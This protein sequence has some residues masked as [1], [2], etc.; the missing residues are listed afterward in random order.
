MPKEIKITPG[1]PDSAFSAV[2]GATGLHT[3]DNNN[4]TLNQPL[5]R[6]MF[7]SVLPE[8]N[9]ETEECSLDRSTYSW[10]SKVKGVSGIKNS[11]KHSKLGGSVNV[12]GGHGKPSS[13]KS[14]GG[15][16]IGGGSSSRSILSEES[17]APSRKLFSS[18]PSK[19]KR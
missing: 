4:I 1:T 18:S 2:S 5:S 6:S 16:L 7:K 11:S 8:M 14:R 10:S 12:N 19:G 3:T 15:F 17:D 13:A 9:S